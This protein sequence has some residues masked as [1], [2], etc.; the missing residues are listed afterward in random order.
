MNR[1]RNDALLHKETHSLSLSDRF[2]RLFSLRNKVKWSRGMN[3]KTRITV[4]SVFDGMS[5]A[6]D[7]FTDLMAERLSGEDIE[8]PVNDRQSSENEDIYGNNV[9][10]FGTIGYTD[11]VIHHTPASGK[12]G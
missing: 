8:V 3:G 4:S 11:E 6:V 10:D 2:G 9:V 7:I 12:C 1:N 5:D